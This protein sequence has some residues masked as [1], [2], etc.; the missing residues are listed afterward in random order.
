MPAWALYTEE[1]ER[2]KERQRGRK[3]EREREIKNMNVILGTL[4]KNAGVA[5]TQ[6][7]NI[8]KI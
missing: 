2:K 4:A 6:S 3:R 1:E 8:T 7:P 5:Y